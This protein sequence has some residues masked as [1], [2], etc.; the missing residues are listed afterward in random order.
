M[1]NSDKRNS[2]MSPNRNEHI[3]CGECLQPISPS[4]LRAIC[5]NCSTHLHL[6]A[7][8][9]GLQTQTWKSKGASNQASWICVSC[10]KVSGANSPMHSQSDLINNEYSNNGTGHN[11]RNNSG[12]NLPRQKRPR[13]GDDD[14]D[15]IIL[16]NEND[17]ESEAEHL[18]V[19][20][21]RLIKAFK[22]LLKKELSPLQKKVREIEE[23]QSDH[24]GRIQT[25]ENTIATLQTENQL[26]KEK[27]MKSNSAYSIAEQYSRKRNIIVTGVPKLENETSES[28]ADAVF[29]IVDVEKQPWDIIAAHR[30]PRR[31]I[32]S[33][34]PANQPTYIYP[35]ILKLHN[36][37]KK[38]E[39]LK[40]AKI[41]QPK[42]SSLGGAS[43]MKIYF[44]EHLTT[45]TKDLKMKAKQQLVNWKFIWTK[46]GIVKARQTD[47][48]KVYSIREE[49][50]LIPLVGNP[51]PTVLDPSTT[52]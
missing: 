16:D 25:L 2:A 47:G 4:K 6:N 51:I 30:L 10:R 21:G 35:I 46:D 32:K 31:E 41:K 22:V 7:N 34:I 9:S 24:N 39:L 8:C 14:D 27:M 40:A 5:A 12:G 33:S 43:N 13:A 26:L 44:N 11:T 49:G 36:I 1:Y 52:K 15:E 38:E 3:N 29:K 50:D 48:S 42:A 28:L 23:A 37:H 19:S 17:N 45:A 20:E 18:T